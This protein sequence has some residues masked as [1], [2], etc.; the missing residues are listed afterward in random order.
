MDSFAWIKTQSSMLRSNGPQPK[1]RL[2]G[3][4]FIWLPCRHSMW[5]LAMGLKLSILS[6]PIL[7][8]TRPSV[9]WPSLCS[10]RF[11]FL[12]PKMLVIS[13]DI[14]CGTIHA[15]GAL[16]LLNPPN[17]PI[18]STPESLTFKSLSPVFILARWALRLWWYFIYIYFT[19]EHDWTVKP[20]GKHSL[21]ESTCAL[22]CLFS[23]RSKALSHCTCQSRTRACVLTQNTVC[24]SAWKFL[25][26]PFLGAVSLN[27]QWE[28]GETT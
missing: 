12:L 22:V 2:S 5:N 3:P 20:H 11:G 21:K 10:P 17:Q 24:G 27:N 9:P 8:W 26:S 19:R 6:T 14:S 16:P 25:I 23:Y 1:R 28:S 7:L 18:G 13:Q 4:G 15:T